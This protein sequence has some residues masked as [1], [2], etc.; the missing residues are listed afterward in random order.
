MGNADQLRGRLAIITGGAG[1]LGREHARAL[2]DIGADV[3][4]VDVDSDGLAEATAELTSQF[5]DSTILSSVTS[6]F[7]RPAL[8]SLSESL[9]SSGHLINVLIN[10]A[11]LDPKVGT[12]LAGSATASFEH[13]PLQQWNA[14][15]E[16]GLTGPFL[17][18]QIF[19]SIMAAHGAGVILN[20]ASDLS[21]ISPDQRIYQEGPIPTPLDFKKPI[22]YSVVKTALIGLTRYLATYWAESGVRVNALSPGGVEAGQD[23]RFIQRLTSRIPLGRM[24]RLDEYRGAVRFLCTDDSSYMTGQNIVMDGG[25]SVW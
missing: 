7:D 4:L 24:A 16:V 2:L 9:L 20:I 12:S 1:R 22:S 10:N 8:V 15:I 21:V 19:G 3:C 6:V 14:E 17:C 5:R 13:F 23:E 18:S 25:R 11:A